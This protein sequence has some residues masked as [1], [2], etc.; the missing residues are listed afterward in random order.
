MPIATAAFM[1]ER[2][3]AIA[4]APAPEAAFLDF[5]AN[6][7]STVEGLHHDYKEKHDR[8]DAKLAE[9]DRKNLAKAVSGFANGGGGI[10]IWGI[11]DG[12]LDPKPIKEIQ[13]FLKNVL[14]A[15]PMSTDPPPA[16]M[17]GVFIATKDDATAG[18]AVLFVPES[19][20]GPHRVSIKHAEVQNHYYMRTTS[21]F[22]VAPHA[23]LADMFGRRPRPRLEIHAPK[24]FPYGKGPSSFAWSLE[25]DIH[26]AGRATARDLAI[27][28]ERHPD[29]N[30]VD[31][32]TWR[33]LGETTEAKLGKGVVFELLDRRVL[34][35]G[36]SIAFSGA[37]LNEGNLSSGESIEMRCA[38]FCDGAPPEYVVLRGT[39]QP[40]P[41]R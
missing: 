19:D 3:R 8:R 25:F 1:F 41:R 15:A 20:S 12:S 27:A 11:E 37:Y 24:T 30:A 18:Y 26:N 35:P 34:H 39:L 4:T 9:S 6:Y 2:L 40:K 33:Q 23:Q 38:L 32:Q 29:L 16:G 7:L 28:F 5:C 31:R 13:T 36:M 21:N 17:D 14:D 22:V 10:L